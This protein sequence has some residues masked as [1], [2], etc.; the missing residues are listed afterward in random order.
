MCDMER[1]H[2]EDLWPTSPYSPAEQ[3]QIMRDL[4]QSLKHNYSPEDF[5]RFGHILDLT[6]DHHE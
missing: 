2:D 5:D 1:Q 4:D 6:K 3:Q